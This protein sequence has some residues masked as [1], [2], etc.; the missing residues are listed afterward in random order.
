MITWTAAPL[1]TGASIALGPLFPTTGVPRERKHLTILGT[2]SLISTLG[3]AV[4][5]VTRPVHFF[6]RGPGAARTAVT[7]STGR[8][9]EY[10]ASEGK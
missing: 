5:T 3:L 2:L 10:G 7:K 4:G 9:S 8:P 1:P 6:P